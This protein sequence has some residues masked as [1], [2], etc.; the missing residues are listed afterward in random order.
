[1]REL[2]TFKAE[3]EIG[4]GPIPAHGPG[5]EQPQRFNMGV[6]TEQLRQP[7][8]DSFR[9]TRDESLGRQCNSADV[10]SRSWSRR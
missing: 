5:A 1:M 10:A 8:L 9:D 3:V 6:L 2:L 7:L 4:T